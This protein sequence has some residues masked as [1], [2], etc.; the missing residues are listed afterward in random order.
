[1]RKS[2]FLLP[3]NIFFNK[4][5]TKL[6]KRLRLLDKSI[7]QVKAGQGYLFDLDLSKKQCSLK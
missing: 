6:P 1:M 4:F 5:S 3:K 2:W 7:T